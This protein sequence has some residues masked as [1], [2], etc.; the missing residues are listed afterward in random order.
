M[1]Y[2]LL[3]LTLISLSACESLQKDFNTFSRNAGSSAGR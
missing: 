1:K 2:T 3:F